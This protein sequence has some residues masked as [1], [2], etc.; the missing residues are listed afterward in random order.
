MG[1][2][3]FKRIVLT[4]LFLSILTGCNK[5]IKSNEGMFNV[6]IDQIEDVKI[7]QPFEIHGYLRN[8]TSQSIE[9]SFG[10]GLFTY[11]IFDE[12]GNVVPVSDQMLVVN[13]IGYDTSL[14]AGE[15]YRNNGEKQRS[16]EFYQFTIKKPGHY[17]VK[18]VAEFSVKD[19]EGNKNQKLT[20][21]MYDFTVK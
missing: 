9:I 3:I 4:T 16:K 6:G 8:N 7:N 19:E 10:A 5:T 11:K 13:D 1:A 20:S 18:A 14:G 2:F 17:K 15:V 12:Y 21:K